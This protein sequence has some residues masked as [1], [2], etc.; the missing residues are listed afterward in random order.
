MKA[1]LILMAILLG[2][3]VGCVDTADSLA[4]EYRNQINEGLDAMMLI[5]DEATANQMTLRVFKPMAE[6]FK[7]IDRR[8]DIVNGNRTKKEFI[9]E[10]GKGDGVRTFVAEV[11][12]NRKRYDKELARLKKLTDQVKQNG[13]CPALQNV[14]SGAALASLDSQLNKTPKLFTLLNDIKNM[15]ADPAVLADIEARFGVKMGDLK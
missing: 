11:M 8:C 3:L 13:E 7:E 15:K 1:R 9:N 4:R 6:R 14:S 10:F 12:V 2:M 5:N